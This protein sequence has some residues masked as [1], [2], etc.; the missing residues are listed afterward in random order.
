MHSNVAVP[1][2]PATD[3][4]TDEYVLYVLPRAFKHIAASAHENALIRSNQLVTEM[5]IRF[6]ASPHQP[7]ENQQP[8]KYAYP[9]RYEF[10]N[11]QRNAQI[12]KYIAEIGVLY[13]HRVENEFLH[14]RVQIF[15]DS[16]G[17]HTVKKKNRNTAGRQSQ[18]AIIAALL[19]LAFRTTVSPSRK[20][21]VSAI[22]I[23]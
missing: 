4:L 8:N 6:Y 18:S 23:Y 2:Y 22:I 7:A 16:E 20:P 5:K 1:E 3:G 13:A 14:F 9:H 15:R 10:R 11:L 12:H 21:S 17:R 19:I